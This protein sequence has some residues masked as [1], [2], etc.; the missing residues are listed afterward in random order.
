MEGRV[1]ACNV[2]WHPQPPASG[3]VLVEL[4]IEAD[5]IDLDLVPSLSE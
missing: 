5:D 4:P 2:L 1:Q 3:L